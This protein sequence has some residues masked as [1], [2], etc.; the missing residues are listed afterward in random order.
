MSFKNKVVIITGASSGIGAAAAKM[1]SDEGAHVVMV[2]RNETSL[3]AVAKQCPSS[4]VIRADVTNDDDARRVINETIKKFGQIDVLVNNAGMTIDNGG[5]LGSDMMQAYDSIM[6][7]NIR[8]VVHLTTLA[9]PH[10]IKT[11][12]NIVNI[13]STAGMVAINSP[14]MISYCVSKAALDHFTVCA[15]VELGLHGVRVNGVNP[16]P[17]KTGFI[18]NAKISVSW[19]DA[20]RMTLLNRVSDPEEIADLIMF[21]AS[22]RAKGITGSKYVTDNG[23]LIKRS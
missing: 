22:D 6:S 3:S 2:G 18:D 13:S 12:G 8:A 15:A 20:S 21:L 7:I 19:D 16:G 9:A 14:G 11:K 5:L 4:L 23:M 17:V 1:F 10:L